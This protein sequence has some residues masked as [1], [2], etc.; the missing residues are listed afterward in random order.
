MNSTEAFRPGIP[1]ANRSSNRPINTAYADAVRTCVIGLAI[2]L[3]ITACSTGSGLTTQGQA[4][5][6]SSIATSPPGSN[7]EV[8][9]VLDGDSLVVSV[10]GQEAEV[11]LIGINAPEGSECHGDQSR[12]TLQD[13]LAA[14][15]VTLVSDIEDTDQYG[16]LLRYLYVRGLNVNLALLANGD[17]IALQGDHSGDSE[18]YAVSDAAAEKGLG[19]WAPDACGESTPPTDVVIT[20]YEYNPAGRDEDA[21]NDEWVAIANEGGTP[22]DMSEWILRDESTQHRY[23]FPEGFELSPHSEVSVHSGCG[24]DTSSDL[25]W[26]A[27]GP[28]WSNG[29][30]T[31]ILQL[32]GGTVVARDRF[33]GDF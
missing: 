14:G 31:V 15:E 12:D 25:H 24:T 29:G 16:R 26:C 7:A 8:V 13:L 4:T 23:Y 3:V 30:D 10:E 21:L 28:V 11:R 19:M 22:V 2:A 5:P 20:D 17:A 32:P 6:A 1:P 9:R 27:G 18:F 33:S